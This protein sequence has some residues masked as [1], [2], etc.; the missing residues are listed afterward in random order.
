LQGGYVTLCPVV[1][2]DLFGTEMIAQSFGMW[3]FA[4]G[5]AGTISSPIGGIFIMFKCLISKL[6]IKILNI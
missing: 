2:A 5:L 6:Y 4:C 1:L 3:L